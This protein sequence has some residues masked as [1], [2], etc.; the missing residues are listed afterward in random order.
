MMFAPVL[1]DVADRMA[2][3]APGSR[4]DPMR[5]AYRLRDAVSLV[6]PDWVVTHHD[7]RAEADAVRAA[8]EPDLLDITLAACPP[9]RDYVTSTRVLAAL[10]PGGVVAA[11][12]TGPVAMARALAAG[13]DRADVDPLD[14]GDLLAEL[15]SA[16]V[17]AGASRI[18]VWEAGAP[19][20][21]V[22]EAH[23]P[24][25]R[26]LRTLGVPG[27]LCGGAETTDIGYAVHALP[28]RGVGA[29]LIDPE[30]FREAHEPTAF[31]TLWERWSVCPEI[32][33]VPAAGVPVLISDGPV[34]ADCAMPILRAAGQRRARPSG[35]LPGP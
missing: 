13:T 33:R 14:C 22:R 15:L 16:Y 20:R 12:I 27:V 32:T 4:D 6:R 8:A 3:V 17:E 18:V 7:L 30:C 29:A 23:S 35:E 24:L 9:V 31:D 10:Y 28:G 5:R 26:K 1:Q 19:A 11:S 34:P 25:V 21:T 2:G